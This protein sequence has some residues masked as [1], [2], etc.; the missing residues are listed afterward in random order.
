M[1]TLQ[2]EQQTQAVALERVGHRIKLAVLE[3]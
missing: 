3:L 1:Q 2:A